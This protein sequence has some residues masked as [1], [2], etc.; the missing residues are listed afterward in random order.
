MISIIKFP[1]ANKHNKMKLK[2]IL[3]FAITLS[4]LYCTAGKN[5]TNETTEISRVVENFKVNKE[6]RTHKDVI[7]TINA[8]KPNTNKKCDVSVR[9]TDSKGEVVYK[10]EIKGTEVTEISDDRVV[11]GNEY[12]PSLKI[13][14]DHNSGKIN[15][16]I[17]E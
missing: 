10:S 15:G 3:L 11:I 8:T 7:V 6:Y 12:W 5:K 13:N 4:S 17:R 1:I 9:V 16:I 14:K 2:S